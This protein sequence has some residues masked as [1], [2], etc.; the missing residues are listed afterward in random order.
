VH[1]YE[2]G[3][4]EYRRYIYIRRTKRGGK[5]TQARRRL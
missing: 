2:K 3:G 5:T 1:L 4:I